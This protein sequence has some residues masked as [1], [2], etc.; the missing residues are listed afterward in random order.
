M[1]AAILAL[2]TVSLLEL[3][4]QFAFPRLPMSVIEQMP[5]FRARMGF[6]LDTAHGVQEYPASELVEFEISRSSGDLYKL[7]CLSPADAPP[8]DSYRVEFRR[9][10][11]GFRNPEPWPDKVKVAV[12][13]DSFTAAEAIVAPYWRELSDSMLVVGLPGSGTLQQQRLLEAYAL[14]RQ[15]DIVILAYFAGN[16]L[17]DNLTFYRQAREDQNSAD[18]P[19]VRKNPLNYSV[20][21]NIAYA[22][23]S[24]LLHDADAPCKFPQTARTEPPTPL[25]FYEAFLSTFALNSQAL[26]ESE[27][28]R[29]TRESIGAMATTLRA[30]DSQL[31]LMYIPQKAE[32]YWEFL[33]ADS[34]AALLSGSDDFD[35]SSSVSDNLAAQRNLMAE[36][37]TELEIGFLDLTLPLSNA[38]NS[39]EQP[40]FFADTHWNQTGHNIARIALLDFLNQSNL[41]M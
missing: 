7:T 9:D 14:P 3:A 13:G 10:A 22:V 37:A 38:I 34:K 36:L 20:L 1:R 31:I 19:Q 24:I 5:Q 4:L 8:F 41:D 12:I 25:A 23:R 6:Q 27:M 21:F 35:S 39:G 16:D 15:P 17:Q 28:Y 26:R 29:I 40:Y 18:E 30:R 32:L 11:Q 2:L 33:S